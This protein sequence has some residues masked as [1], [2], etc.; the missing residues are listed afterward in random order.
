MKTT[1]QNCGKIYDDKPCRVLSGKS[2][3]CSRECTYSAQTTQIVITCKVCGKTR[4]VKKGRAIKE[5]PKFCSMECYLKDK[6]GRNNN[7]TGSLRNCIICGAIFY[8]QQ[9]QINGG[10]GVCCSNECKYKYTSDL[11]RGEK[12]VAWKGGE[13]K[14]K[15]GYVFLKVGRN[16]GKHNGYVKRA[17][18]SLM[19][20]KQIPSGHVIHHINGIKDDDRP[21]N[22][23]LMS[24]LDHNRLHAKKRVNPHD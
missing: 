23:V 10:R 7:K 16:T 1:C 19:G 17:T 21:E 14:D 9:N 18:I 4:N 22:L 11:F 3:F 8:V 5:N 20:G 15:D 6:R 24:R 2:K 12:S 13:R